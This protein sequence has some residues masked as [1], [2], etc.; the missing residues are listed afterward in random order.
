MFPLDLSDYCPINV[1]SLLFPIF[2][3]KGKGGE[4][5]VYPVGPRTGTRTPYIKKAKHKKNGSNHEKKEMRY[6]GHLD[7]SPHLY[8]NGA[9]ATND[10]PRKITKKDRKI[11]SKNAKTGTEKWQEE[12]SATRK[13]QRRAHPKH[14]GFEGE[15]PDTVDRW[16]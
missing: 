12:S 2:R 6:G 10:P 4:R 7:S 9:E 15:T 13:R 1:V 16:A 3:T 14:W 11:W 8:K 5:T